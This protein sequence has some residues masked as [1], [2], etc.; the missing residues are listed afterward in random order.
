MISFLIISCGLFHNGYDYREE[1]RQVK[2]F[3]HEN[4]FGVFDHLVDV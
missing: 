4:S 3:E 2:L 1:L